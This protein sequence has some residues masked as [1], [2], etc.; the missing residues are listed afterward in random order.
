MMAKE[1]RGPIEGSIHK[2][3]PQR[4]AT[5]PTDIY[6]SNKTKTAAI[7]KRVTRLM[8]KENH[9]HVT[10]HG[11]GAMVIRASSMALAVQ[12]ALENQVLLKPKTETVQLIDDIIPEDMDKD[13]ETQKRAN[14]VI[15]IQI[16]ATAGLAALQKKTGKIIHHPSRNRRS[17]KWQ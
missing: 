9:Q 11:L 2:R 16:E 13:L 4:P 15:H 14:S 1:K 7:I 12:Q 8:L 6:V 5:V 3:A 17:R 10:L